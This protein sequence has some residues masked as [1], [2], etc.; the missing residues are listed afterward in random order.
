LAIDVPLRAGS[1]NYLIFRKGKRRCVHQRTSA[2]S[3]CRLKEGADCER[4]DAIPRRKTAGARV[5]W[6]ILIREEEPSE[7]AELDC[8][9][10]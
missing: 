8:G 10:W 3:A 6:G 7:M 9:R 5:N 4:T 1:G 2:V